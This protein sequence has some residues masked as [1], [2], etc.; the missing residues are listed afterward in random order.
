MTDKGWAD[1]SG[2][3]E[4]D[5]SFTGSGPSGFDPGR[6]TL[7][8]ERVGRVLNEVDYDCGH[9]ITGDNL[10]VMDVQILHSLIKEAR[11]GNEA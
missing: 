7:A 9:F 8:I 1:N 10:R 2:S 5:P 4:P 3:R 6:I 11:N